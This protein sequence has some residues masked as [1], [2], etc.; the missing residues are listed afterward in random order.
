MNCGY[1]ARLNGQ[2]DGPDVEVG[3]LEMEK[4]AASN[5]FYR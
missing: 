5:C 2:Q 1:I 4:S 3:P